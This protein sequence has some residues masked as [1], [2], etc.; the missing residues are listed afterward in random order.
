MLLV[1]TATANEM[2]TA[3]GADAPAVEQGEVAEYELNGRKLLLAVTGVGM[4]NAAM[5]AGRLLSQYEFDGVINIGIAGAHDIEANPIGSVAFAWRETW[6]EYGLLDED[7]RVDPK[8]IGFPLAEVDGTQIWNRVKF[9]PVNDA[10]KMNVTLG[11]KWRRASS[12]SVNAVT[13]DT[14]R[15]GWLKTKYSGDMENMEGFALGFAAVQAG[16]P[17]LE[18]R[19][20]SNMVGSRLEQDWDIK[21]ALKAL[22][23]IVKTLFSG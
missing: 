4:V 23:G 1:A 11:E 3:F 10:K 16:L 20:I 19:T 14:S 18:V 22:D 17:F 13:G 15:A 21:K 6:P 7:G 8:A 2:K 12:I 5:V 9:N